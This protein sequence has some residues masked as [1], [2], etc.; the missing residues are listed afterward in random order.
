MKRH[1]HA[2][3]VPDTTIA[4]ARAHAVDLILRAVIGTC[5]EPRHGIVLVDHPSQAS[6]EIRYHVAPQTYVL[7][8]NRLRFERAPD[9]S[10]RLSPCAPRPRPPA[11]PDGVVWTQPLGPVQTASWLFDLPERLVDTGMV[12]GRC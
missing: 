10:L 3:P 7:S 6:I 8:T 1:L 12:H 4:A 11:R 2:G 9:G 5:P